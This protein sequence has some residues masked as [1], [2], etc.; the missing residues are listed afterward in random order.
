MKKS[1]KKGLVFEKKS[2]TELQQNDVKNIEGGKDTQFI[3]LSFLEDL[4]EL[5]KPTRN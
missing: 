3:D 5:I 4:T 2:L 1:K